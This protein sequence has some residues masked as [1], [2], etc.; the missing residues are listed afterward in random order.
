MQVNQCTSLAT[1]LSLEAIITGSDALLRAKCMVWFHIVELHYIIK[2]KLQAGPVHLHV[3]PGA[4][5]MILVVE[6]GGGS[7]HRES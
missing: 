6:K 3:R 1:D 4:A 5:A 2:C 7:I